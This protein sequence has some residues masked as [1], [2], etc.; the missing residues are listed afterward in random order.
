MIADDAAKK[1]AASA[2][3]KKPVEK[4]PHVKEVR[5]SPGLTFL[6][7]LGVGGVGP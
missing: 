4:S 7:H 5:I 6:P 1:A 3:S 2:D